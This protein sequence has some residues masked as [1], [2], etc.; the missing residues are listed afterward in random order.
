M[1]GTVNV[2]I[3]Y[4]FMC[5]QKEQ[6]PRLLRVLDSRMSKQIVSAQMYVFLS[7]ITETIRIQ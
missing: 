4:M 1:R 2:R 5:S 7:N 6:K 3:E